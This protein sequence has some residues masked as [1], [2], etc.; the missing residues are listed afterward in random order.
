MNVSSDVRDIASLIYEISGLPIAS[1]IST[2]QCKFSL[3][4][5]GQTLDLVLYEDCFV[6]STHIDNHFA[7]FA[8]EGNI[9]ISKDDKL[10]NGEVGQQIV[11]IIGIIKRLRE[12]KFIYREFYEELIVQQVTL[13]PTLQV[14]HP[15]IL[16]KVISIYIDRT[17][18]V[19]LSKN[20]CYFTIEPAQSF[21]LEE[22]S[23]S[24]Y[25][26][27]SR[28]NVQ[29][30]LYPDNLEFLCKEFKVRQTGDTSDRA[31]DIFIGFLVKT[32]ERIFTPV[33]IETTHKTVH[34]RQL[35]DLVIPEPVIVAP[36][37]SPIV[38]PKLFPLWLL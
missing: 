35:N 1:Y 7:S 11:A 3:N 2:R 15:L 25:L 22:N 9:K 31:F 19:D 28:E 6:L 21:L 38:E 30:I 34:I 10:I 23:A 13:R 14:L 17:T 29:T 27:A 24:F 36:T 26:N 8:Y 37:P 16:S 4:S 18:T 33:Q 20:T 12:F 5:S 32:I